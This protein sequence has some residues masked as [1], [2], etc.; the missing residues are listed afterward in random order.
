MAL[1]FAAIEQHSSGTLRKVK[2]S[3]TFDSSYVTG[4]EALTPQQLGLGEIVGPVEFDQAED[5]Y[6]FK[7]DKANEKI[8]VYAESDV[9]LVVNE[10]V[11]IVTDDVATLFHLP[12]YIVSIVDVSNGVVYR[13]IPVAE[14]GIDNVSVAVNFVTG[15]L[16]FA[17]ADNPAT[18][19]VTYFPQQTSGVFAKANMV[20]DETVIAAAAKVDLANRAAAVQYIYNTTNTAVFVET[21]PGEAP[22]A[23]GKAALLIDDG[24]DT[25]I[26]THSDDDGDTITVTYLKYSGIANPSQAIDDTDITLATEVLDWGLAAGAN[27]RSLVIPG[28]GTRWVGEETGSGNEVGNFSYAADTP[29]DEIVSVNLLTNTYSWNQDNAV[30]TVSIPWLVVDAIYERATRSLSEVPNGTDLSAV[31]TKVSAEGR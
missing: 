26:D 19:T 14:T 22:S 23:T 29:A 31:V 5:G 18:V 30:I 9:P 17:A 2:T 10:E 4:G 15:V 13:I 16:T 1:S 7:Y 21:P 24:G 25:S 11:T 12:A 28:Y 27:Y 3:I 8:L 20:I 6:I